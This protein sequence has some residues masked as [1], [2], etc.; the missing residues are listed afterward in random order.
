MRGCNEGSRSTVEQATVW[1]DDAHPRHFIKVI[2]PDQPAC[3]FYRNMWPNTASGLI[4]R[5]DDQYAGFVADP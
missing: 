3:G 1:S 2:L 5:S 4:D